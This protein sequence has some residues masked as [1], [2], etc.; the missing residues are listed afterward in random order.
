MS[1]IELLPSESL[2]PFD[3]LKPSLLTLVWQK[4]GL[5]FDPLHYCFCRPCDGEMNASWAR[6]RRT[7]LAERYGGNGLAENAGGVR[8]GLL[9]DIQI[10]GSGRNPLAGDQTDYW[11]K[12]GALSLQDGLKEAFWSSVFGAVLPF[13]AATSFAVVSTGS[14]FSTEVDGFRA[15]APRGLLLRKPLLRPAHF[16]R[17]IYM[18]TTGSHKNLLND[19]ARTKLALSV[20]P[21]AFE[22]ELGVPCRSVDDQLSALFEVFRRAAH[23]ISAAR[24][25]RVCHG[26]LTPSNFALNGCWIDFGTATAL[27]SYRDVLTAPGAHSVWS[28]E[29]SLYETIFDLTFYISKYK[30]GDV[31]RHQEFSDVV[32]Q[33]FRDSLVASESLYILHLFGLSE[34]SARRVPSELLVRL[35]E[36]ARAIM[37]LE[38]G[39][40]SAYFGDNRHEMPAPASIVSLCVAI[41][42]CW[43]AGSV[44]D[45]AS[46][47]SGKLPAGL[48]TGLTRGVFELR[49][50]CILSGI[51]ID[52]VKRES[53]RINGPRNALYRRDFDQK[54]NDLVNGKLA[55]IEAE[56][57][58]WIS[59]WV[60]L[61]RDP[62]S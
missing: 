47:L 43:S 17:S 58:T 34:F 31:A 46:I 32:A 29:A 8:C 19:S 16:M 22:A 9:G 38:K 4:P 21:A 2:V 6:G 15:S 52:T 12:H 28:Q 1:A 25:K 13:G 40:P 36:V 37:Q 60:G 42:K 5:T 18:K 61:L 7:L 62:D 51:D 11:H 41:T 23:Q 14:R 55:A 57:S 56:L 48:V 45:A 20:L 24:I 3:A 44:R 39:L 49:D 26:S 10:K 50:A 59:T 33:S 53:I 35:I 30:F 27:G 54:I